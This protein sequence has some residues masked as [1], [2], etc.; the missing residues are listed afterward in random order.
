MVYDQKMS[1]FL[2]MVISNIKNYDPLA[3]VPSMI[4]N[5]FVCRFLFY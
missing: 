5:A 3:G 2:M 1:G 4:S